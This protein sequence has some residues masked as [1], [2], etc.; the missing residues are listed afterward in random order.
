MGNFVEAGGFGDTRLPTDGEEFDE[1]SHPE[2]Q[3]G[4]RPLGQLHPSFMN[5]EDMYP[6]EQ[7][8]Y[9]DGVNYRKPHRS[10]EGSYGETTVPPALRQ[11]Y[12][13]SQR[14]N[15]VELERIWEAYKQLL[16]DQA[17]EDIMD[18]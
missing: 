3:P 4:S 14:T 16:V 2:N 12:L 9:R 13:R 10:F 7:Y 5:D 18:N 17:Q 6:G 15:P 1:G 11:K 8:T